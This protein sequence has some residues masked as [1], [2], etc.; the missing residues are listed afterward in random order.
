MGQ[1]ELFHGFSHVTR[2]VAIERAG[3]AFADGA[4]TTV[5]R[6]DVTAQH[7]RGRAIGPALKNV[8]TASF[9]TNGVEIQA[10]D[11]LQ[12]VI[13]VHRIAETNF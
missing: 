1:V 10:L 6:A 3:C 9:L 4:K 8:G 7:E 5:T 12:D 11:Q 2:F 13:L